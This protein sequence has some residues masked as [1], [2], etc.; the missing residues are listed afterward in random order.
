LSEKDLL[1]YFCYITEGRCNVGDKRKNRE[2]IMTQFVKRSALPLKAFALISAATLVLAG[3]ASAEEEEEAPE[4]E[5][6][7]EQPATTGG[8]LVVGMVADPDTIFPWKA[9]QF[10]A[11][12]MLENVYDT[13]TAFDADLNVVPGLAESWEISADGTVIT[14]DLRDGVQFADGSAF[15]SADVKYSYEAIQVEENA[16]VAAST[17]GGVTSIETPDA[18]TVVLN[19]ATADVGLLANLT[20]V[21]LA[22][23]SSDDTE[24]TLSTGTNGTGPFLMESRTAGQNVVLARNPNYWGDPTPLDTLEFRVLPDEAAIAAA[25]SAGNVQLAVLSDPITA[26]T[27]S[28][29]VTVATTP[30]L[31]YHAL[32]LNARNGSMGDKN[33]RLAIQCAIDRQSVLDTALLGE[34][35]VTGP[36]TSPAYL[37]DP[38]A[39]PCPVR[40]LD[41]AA[42]YLAASGNADGVEIDAIVAQG[43]YAGAVEIAQAVAAQLA[44][45]NI[46]LNLEVLEGGTY[47]DRW[48]AGDF[49]TAI[50]LNGGRPDPDGMYGRYFPST[51]N[52]N[53]VSGYSSDTMDQL[54]ADGKVESDPAKRKAIYAAVSEELESNAVWVWM[55]SGYT[56]TAISDSVTG[57]VPM[58]TGSWQYLR[59]TGL[60]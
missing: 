45:A 24:E 11:F 38:S 37:S 7:V 56:Y 22:I 27:I 3:C 10:Q 59:T 21:N 39:R 5:T 36:I 44:E 35:E 60:K 28:G 50:A 51:G 23:V 16:A 47:I 43:L 15:D 31:S 33:I 42:E 32:M 57:F 20:T 25:M 52:L 9:T 18:D 48:I 13:L 8:A 46:T 1:L 17:I 55:F 58:T 34:G 29:D 26:Q 19:L 49:E 2:G 40:D 4:A 54:F 30:Q 12:R 53:Q 41:K 6:Q 14:F